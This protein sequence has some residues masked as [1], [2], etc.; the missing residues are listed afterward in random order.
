MWH[1]ISGSPQRFL[2]MDGLLSSQRQLCTL[3]WAAWTSLGNREPKSQLV[4]ISMSFPGHRPLLP[5]AQI[6]QCLKRSTFFRF[7]SGTSWNKE[8]FF[9]ERLWQKTCQ[10]FSCPPFPVSWVWPVSCTNM[11]NYP[12]RAPACVSRTTLSL[13]SYQPIV[14]ALSVFMLPLCWSEILFSRVQTF[15]CQCNQN[16]PV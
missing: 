9:E 12:A 15:L 1:Q 2:C 14:I 8:R 11:Q 13:W 7:I 4:T 10:L 16:L 6:M 5:L 3:M